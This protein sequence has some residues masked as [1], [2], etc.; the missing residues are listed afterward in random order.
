MQQYRLTVLFSLFAIAITV[1][2]LYKVIGIVLVLV[3]VGSWAVTLLLMPK[4]I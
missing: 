2:K 4:T 1:I 3:G